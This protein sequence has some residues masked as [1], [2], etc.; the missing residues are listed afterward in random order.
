MPQ[1]NPLKHLVPKFKKVS[2]Q[3]ETQTLKA[4]A[5]PRVGQGTRKRSAYHMA[6][7]NRSKHPLDTPSYNVGR[8]H[9]AD[10]KA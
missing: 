3:P 1:P 9:R 4:N 6:T 2:T 7:A 8:T 5:A 10:H